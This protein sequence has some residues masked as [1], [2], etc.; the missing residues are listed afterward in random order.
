MTVY[1]V[2]AGPLRAN[3]YLITQDGENAVLIDCGG[4]EP[5]LFAKEKGLSVRYVLLT[6]GHF[7][8]IGGCAA[9]QEAGAEVACLDKEA[10]LLSSRANLAADAGVPVPPF[11]ADFTFRG[12]ERLSL[13]GLTINVV[14][15]PGHTPGGACFVCDGCLFTGDTLFF[16][17]VGRTDFPGGSG[18]QLRE[19]VKKLLA[20]DGDM[21]V[22]P[23]HD[24]PT[25]LAHERAYNPFAQ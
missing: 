9:A 7:D 11:R 13:C 12:G 6:H 21:T 25:T 8:H 18:A 3:S 22:Y 16:E 5:L 17:S 15:T 10:P 23:G 2:P 20:L 1:T 14:A 4:K 24:E 19:S